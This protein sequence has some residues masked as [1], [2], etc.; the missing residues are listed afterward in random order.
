MST[1]DQI[2]DFLMPGHVWVHRT[3]GTEATV[4]F[5]S[6]EHLGE[7]YLTTYPQQVIYLDVKGNITTN[8][9]EQFTKNR[10][11]SHVEAK[12]EQAIDNLVAALNDS[13]TLVLEDDETA[14]GANSAEKEDSTETVVG[15]ATVEEIVQ[16][17][18]N[19]L[20]M[21]LTVSSTDALPVVSQEAL[22][23]NLVSY[24]A[25]PQANGDILHE[26]QFALSEEL[27][28]ENIYTAFS[29]DIVRYSA[30]EIKGIPVEWDTF[31][32]VHP[33]VD[34]NGAVIGTAVFLDQSGR[35]VEEPAKAPK[36][37]TTRKVAASKPAAKVEQPKADGD[38]AGEQTTA[39]ET[40]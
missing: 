11:F 18:A 12:V 26:V 35:V 19:P 25:H 38:P 31:L 16:S 27:T 34:A 22:Q 24:S 39:Q 6:N 23:N 14:G 1:E 13:E 37:A 9:I 3:K 40:K 8:T 20:D 10:E 36:T 5:L 28:N 4:L 17:R 15:N 32:G 7:K 29:S 30:L 2:T 21:V 33:K